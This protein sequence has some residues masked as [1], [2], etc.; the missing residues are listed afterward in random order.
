VGALRASLRD[1]VRLIAE[2]SSKEQQAL[3][4]ER[5]A[6]ETHVVRF[7]DIVAGNPNRR[8]RGREE[9]IR[10]L[11]DF[12]ALRE[13]RK[14]VWI[15]AFVCEN[16]RGIVQR[17]G[18][19]VTDDLF[20]QLIRE[21]IHPI[22]P[23]CST[24]RWSPSAV[25]SLAALE[26]DQAGLQSRMASLNQAPLVCR[27]A[28]GNRTAMVKVGLSHLLLDASPSTEPSGS[29][30]AS[31]ASRQYS[32]DRLIAEIDRFTGAEPTEPA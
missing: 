22:A 17:Y 20:L 8:L 3:T 6:I 4:R 14:M 5:E 31:D 10:A 29:P 28:L 19:E 23:N 21:R 11:S 32:T 18:P 7:R 30:V 15:M 27:L 24:F 2:E 16:L 1:V 12:Q 25:V 13:S 26:A 9:G